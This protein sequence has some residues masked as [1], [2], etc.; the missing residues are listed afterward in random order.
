MS[1][2]GVA[3]RL[4]I[5]WDHADAIMDRAVKRGRER[6]QA[7]IVAHLGTDEK[8]VKKAIA[9]SRSSRTWTAARS[10]G[11]AEAGSASR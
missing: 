1:L 4:A 6:R 10:C 8:A 7:R 9:T 2:A 3:R 5:T 11:S